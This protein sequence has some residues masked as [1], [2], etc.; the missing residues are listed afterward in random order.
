MSTNVSLRRQLLNMRMDYKQSQ[1]AKQPAVVVKKTREELR[2]E[3]FDFL[4]EYVLK[5][6][7]DQE[8]GE[9]SSDSSF[10]TSS[11]EDE[12]SVDTADET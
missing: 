4:F 11:S 1:L 9:G 2:Q 10:C 7:L 12:Q 3:N 6:N 8:T 5:H